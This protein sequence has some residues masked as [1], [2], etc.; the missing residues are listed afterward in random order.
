MATD[1]LAATCEKCG[2]ANLGP[3]RYCRYCGH[4]LM[5][6]PQYGGALALEP[7]RGAAFQD[8]SV[9]EES[10]L[11]LQ[12]ATGSDTEESVLELEPVTGPAAGKPAPS[13][14]AGESVGP[15]GR[16][17]VE[18]IDEGEEEGLALEDEPDEDVG[19]GTSAQTK[20]SL[21]PDF[22]SDAKA[23][24]GEPGAAP[25]AGAPKT[26]PAGRPPP[27]APTQVTQQPGRPTPPAPGARKTVPAG[28]LPPTAPPQVTQQPGQP[29]PP[30][31]GARKSVP[32][33]KLPPTA[34][35]QVTQQ[36][37]QPA[38]PAVRSVHDAETQE[39]DVLRETAPAK[40]PP[41]RPAI[42]PESEAPTEQ[43]RPPQPSAPPA[44]APKPAPAA[45][46]PPA[47]APAPPPASPPV[48]ER[49]RS[50][51][52]FD[53][54]DQEPPPLEISS[55]DLERVERARK[56]SFGGFVLFLV[57]L[58]AVGAVLYFLWDKGYLDKITDFIVSKIN[59]FFIKEPAK[60]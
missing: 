59:E 8:S 28:K 43:S 36:P 30:A 13:P 1:T 25:A 11:D 58:A 39:V 55:D 6:Q 32:A 24:D 35:P 52:P 9:T 53:L 12:L 42:I 57:M 44:P 21:P 37:G 40:P 3:R 19:S 56:F 15:K 46:A 4:G 49:L 47:P 10:V 18:V 2:Y 50:E 20:L 22:L 34:P 29:A 41:P 5:A 60:P 27:T 31:P 54:D 33:G 38:P 26:V 14:P 7:A 23:A 16:P 48:Q 17:K 51:Q 45:A